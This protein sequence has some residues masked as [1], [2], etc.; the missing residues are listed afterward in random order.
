MS[1]FTVTTTATHTDTLRHYGK[2]AGLGYS[3]DMEIDSDLPRPAGPNTHPHA[4]DT[5]LELTPNQPDDQSQTAATEPRH[6]I[7]EK[8]PV[9]Q[10]APSV[11]E[12]TGMLNAATEMPGQTGK[13]L[14][15][16]PA[17]FTLTQGS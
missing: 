1:A 17:R 5:S 9:A 8:P 7:P 4:M 6:E 16:S 10:D 15:S 14:D 3:Q 2:L 12:H 11:A 13:I